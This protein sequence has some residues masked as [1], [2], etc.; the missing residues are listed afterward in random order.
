MPRRRGRHASFDTPACG[1]LLRMRMGGARPAPHSSSRVGAPAPYRGTPCPGRG[2][3][4]LHTFRH[5]RTCSGHPLRAVALRAAWMAGTSPGMTG[6][7]GRRA[8]SIRGFAATRDEGWVIGATRLPHPEQR[9]SRASPPSSRAAAEPRTL[10]LILSSGGAAYRRARVGASQPAAIRG[11]RA[12][13]LS[14]SM[15]HRTSASSPSPI[16]PSTVAVIV[17]SGAKG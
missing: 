5:A 15:P 2:R 12:S 13:A 11:N 9:P 17:A 8:P 3:A 14:R 1:G 6:W 4:A 10:A 16:S 7:G